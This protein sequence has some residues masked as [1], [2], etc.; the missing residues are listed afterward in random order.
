MV[1]IVLTTATLANKAKDVLKSA[2]IQGTV[3][4]IRGG[5]AAGCLFGVSIAENVLPK[6]LKLLENAG[7]RV[8]S[9]KEVKR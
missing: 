9:V 8:L 6:A 1:Q 4:K 5:T 7:I 2:G 3:G